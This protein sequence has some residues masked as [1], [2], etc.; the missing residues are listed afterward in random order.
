[1]TDEEKARE[2]ERS[3]ETILG[4]PV[5]IGADERTDK[6]RNHLIFAAAISVFATWFGLHFRGDLP[7]FGLPI[8]GLTDPA[9]YSALLIFVIYQLAHYVWCAWDAFLE[10]RLR[11]TGMRESRVAPGQYDMPEA[12]HADDPRQSTLYNLVVKTG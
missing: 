7:F 9:A 11:I 2:K 4:S 8:T 3:V 12:D 6:V 10:W 1:M 5:F